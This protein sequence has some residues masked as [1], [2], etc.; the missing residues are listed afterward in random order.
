MPTDRLSVMAKAYS[1]QSRQLRH[2]P[3]GQLRQATNQ[4]T[5]SLMLQSSLSVPLV[6]L[7][8][9]CSQLLPI[10]VEINKSLPAQIKTLGVQTEV[11]EAQINL[12]LEVQIK[13]LEMETKA[14][15]TKINVALVV[16]VSVME[17]VDLN[18]HTQVHEFEWS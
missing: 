14:S 3:S 1:S 7:R 15:E 8:E 18:I 17:A 11:S 16:L 2:Q 4:T 6:N 10:E 9:T 13:A 5:A 12:L